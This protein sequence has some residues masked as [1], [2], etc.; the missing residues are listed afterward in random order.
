MLWESDSDNTGKCFA[1][2]QCSVSHKSMRMRQWVWITLNSIISLLKVQ[3]IYKQH[4]FIM[5]IMCLVLVHSV[6]ENT[7]TNNINHKHERQEFDRYCHDWVHLNQ[8][9]VH[10]WHD[11]RRDRTTDLLL[12]SCCNVGDIIPLFCHRFPS[13]GDQIHDK[14]LYRQTPSTF[15]HSKSSN[16]AYYPQL[17]TDKFSVK[18]LSLF[19]HVSLAMPLKVL[20]LL[21]VSTSNRWSI[22][23]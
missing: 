16:I 6:Q 1:S 18:L 23:P 13:L 20:L 7:A 17:T 12:L 9:T 11:T 4:Y 3:G 22:L 2:G 14:K 10:E 5:N 21:P 19:Q 15:L 8:H